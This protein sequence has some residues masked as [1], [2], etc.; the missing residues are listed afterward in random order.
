[1]YLDHEVADIL[2]RER[3]RRLEALELVD[4]TMTPDDDAQSPA[5]MQGQMTP[6]QRSVSDDWQERVAKCSLEYD[7]VVSES[8]V[9]SAHSDEALLFNYD[10]QDDSAEEVAGPSSKG[11]KD[12]AFAMSAPM[13]MG[14]YRASKHAR[15]RINTSLPDNAG[16]GHD[17]DDGWSR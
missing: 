8:P 14:P 5:E 16:G 13:P 1:M 2:D 15:S 4:T 17:D 7:T 12:V 10:G 11:M 9:P 6:E 3:Q